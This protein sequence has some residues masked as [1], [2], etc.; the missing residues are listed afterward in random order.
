MLAS[1]EAIQRWWSACTASGI[2]PLINTKPDYPINAL[3]NLEN[4]C[5][6]PHGL[7]QMNSS[8]SG[9]RIS[10]K[11]NNSLWV[12]PLDKFRCREC[13]PV[14]LWLETSYK[15]CQ[16]EEPKKMGERAKNA[17]L[18]HFQCHCIPYYATIRYAA[19]V[20]LDYDGVFLSS[21]W[22]P[23][24]IMNLNWEELTWVRGISFQ[25]SL[26]WYFR[27]QPHPA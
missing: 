21:I 16:L 6:L 7:D 22:N 14:G 1:Y 13:M 19:I 4:T 15:N 2:S 3:Y 11:T 5:C 25:S 9:M 12:L 27:S 24:R 20:I 23:K 10:I 8:F 26:F 18:F 17:Y